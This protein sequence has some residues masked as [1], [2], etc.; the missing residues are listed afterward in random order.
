MFSSEDKVK[1]IPVLP[2]GLL[3]CKPSPQS[4]RECSA[5]T[6][7][8]VTPVLRRLKMNRFCS[9]LLTF[10]AFTVL[11]PRADA[12]PILG[13]AEDF[14][15]L[16]GST[17]T[18]TGETTIEGNVGL[19]P[20]TSITG[21]ETV[22]LIGASTVHNSDAVASLAQADNVI[23]YNAL[24]GLA[25]T[26]VLTGTDL[27]GLTLTSGIY[28]FAT[29]AQLT[30]TLTLDAQGNNFAYWVFQIGSTLTTATDSAVTFVN[31]GSEG[32]TYDGLFWQVGSSA[33]LGTGTD[34]E[35]N[36]LALTSITLDTN[37]SIHNGRA[38]AQN[39]AVTLIA[40]DI[41]IYSPFPNLG[42]LS[43]GLEFNDEG[44]LVPM[45]ALPTPEVPEP[46]TLLLLGTGFAGLFGY[47]RRMSAAKRLKK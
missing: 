35:G 13:S 10:A 7:F 18:N 37:A 41:S 19:Y 33:T 3:L 23:A 2:E 45:V 12:G 27:G 36:I 39:G 34:F 1:S 29:S 8:F 6:V 20:G 25:P 5:A 14:A 26:D 43:G 28:F 4:T 44:E 46:G 22:T 31:V 47:K 15:I 16:A 11:T 9:L 24:A 30:G 32:G 17:I 21:F 42:T 38:L 40:N